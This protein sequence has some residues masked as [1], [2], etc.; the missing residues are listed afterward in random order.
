MELAAKL[1]IPHQINNYKRKNYFF[2]KIHFFNRHI[3]FIRT[4]AASNIEINNKQQH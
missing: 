1:D 4:F 2:I 3:K